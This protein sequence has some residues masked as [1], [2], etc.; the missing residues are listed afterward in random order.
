LQF[1]LPGDRIRRRRRHR[2]GMAGLAQ[3]L[4]DG[5]DH[6]SPHLPLAAKT[7]LALGRVHVDIHRGG[8]E[9]E[10]QNRHRVAALG[11]QR[12]VGFDQRVIERAAIHRPAVD[13]RDHLMAC[14]AGDARPADQ[15][16]EA[17]PLLLRIDGEQ[18]GREL[19]AEY[20]RHALRQ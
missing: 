19:T 7:H 2:G 11:Q 14:G 12:R 15:A 9:V 17:A 1:R 8:I 6:K 20:L 10:K 13:E 4:Q 16:G 18:I 5:P 3:L